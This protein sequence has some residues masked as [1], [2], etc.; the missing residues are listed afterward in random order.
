MVLTC[1]KGSSGE[2]HAVC[3]VMHDYQP[4]KLGFG[5]A[6]ASPELYPKENES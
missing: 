4:D 5:G 2:S 3:Q 1:L 6:G